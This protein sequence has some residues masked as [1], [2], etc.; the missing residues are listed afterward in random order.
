MIRLSC[1]LVLAMGLSAQGVA[2][3]LTI[4]RVFGPEVPTGPYKHPACMT[5]LSDG[6]LYL[7]YY[8]GSGEY[9]D[10]STVYGARLRQDE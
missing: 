1:C 2:G 3:E 6:D 5:E 8:G 7:V 10:D 9:S 4:E